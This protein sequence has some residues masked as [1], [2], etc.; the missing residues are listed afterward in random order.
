MTN[1]NCSGKFEDIPQ[2]MSW[3]RWPRM[4]MLNSIRLVNWPADVKPP[5]PDFDTKALGTTALRLLVGDYIKYV[6]DGEQGTPPDIPD[7]EKWTAGEPPERLP[8]NVN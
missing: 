3:K 4:A 5:G 2:K 7:F 6:E 1:L 8:S